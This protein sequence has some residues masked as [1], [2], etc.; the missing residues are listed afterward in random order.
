M[1]NTADPGLITESASPGVDMETGL[2]DDS[3]PPAYPA[4]SVGSLM[5]D[6]DAAQAAARNARAQAE[7]FA[8]LADDSDR[9]AAALQLAIDQLASGLA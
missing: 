9:R 1:T 8:A 5:R 3:M 4:T 2:P 7:Q 6:R